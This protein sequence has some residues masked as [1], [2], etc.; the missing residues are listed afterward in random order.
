MTS[1]NF[2]PGKG[3]GW[4]ARIAALSLCVALASVPAAP[5]HSDG[6]HWVGPAENYFGTVAVWVHFDH[7]TSVDCSPPRA[8]YAKSQ[9]I[10]AYVACYLRSVAVIRQISMDLNGDVVADASAEA[11]VFASGYTTLAENG[12]PPAAR[13]VLYRVCG[14]RTFD[15]D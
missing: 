2:R 5:A 4:L 6:V 15:V 7:A 12:M 10:Y 14:Y 1:A 13:R 8:C 9:W 11:V 3:S